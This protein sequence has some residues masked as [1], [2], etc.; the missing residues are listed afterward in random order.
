[1][2]FDPNVSCSK[3]GFTGPATGGAKWASLFPPVCLCCAEAALA[4][5]LESN[6]RGGLSEQERNELAVAER[7]AKRL[8]ETPEQR[9]ARL[10]KKRA[11]KKA[12]RQTEAGKLARQRE[13]QRRAERL[14]A[15]ASLAPGRAPP[16]VLGLSGKTAGERRR[17]TDPAEALAERYRRAAPVPAPLLAAALEEADTESRRRDWLGLWPKEA[18]GDGGTDS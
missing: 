4:K 11:L 3:C 2:T 18:S 5:S 13:A 9:S 1:M 10:E 6:P 14:A 8:A 15:K 12:W 17:P 16:P 7:R